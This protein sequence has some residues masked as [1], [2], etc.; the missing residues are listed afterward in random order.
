MKKAVLMLVAATVALSGVL[1]TSES[2]DARP[3]YKA[4]WDK[5]YLTDGSAMAKALPDGK[6]TCNICHVGAKDKKN[7]NDYGKALSKL[8]TKDDVMNTQ[9][10]VESLSKVEAEKSGDKTFGDLIKEGK[11]PLTKD[12]P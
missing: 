10:I 8:L 9:K 1:V 4:Q 2:V 3:P 12:E 7:R 5:K 6:S 11:L